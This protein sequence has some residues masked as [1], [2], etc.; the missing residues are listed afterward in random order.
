GS[1]PSWHSSEPAR[2][3]MK[4]TTIILGAVIGTAVLAV[5]AFWLGAV[6]Y[7]S[8]TM[9]QHEGRLRRLLDKQPQAGLLLPA[10]ADE[11][12][13]LVAA[14]VAPEQ[15]QGLARERGQAK[16][17]EIEQKASRWGHMYVFNAGDVLYFVFFD[18]ASVM[19]DF[20]VVSR[21]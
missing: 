19:R 11:G 3:G 4:K 1:R 20:T 6:G 16:A 17:A 12:T 8:R 15:S 13:K 18:E 21:R 14:P 9:T 10:F 7:G 2:R 5:I